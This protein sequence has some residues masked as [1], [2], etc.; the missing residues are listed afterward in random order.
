MASWQFRPKRRPEGFYFEPILRI[1]GVR[2]YNNPLAVYLIALEVLLPLQSKTTEKA[3]QLQAVWQ[4]NDSVANDY[5]F[6]A[7]R[8]NEQSFLRLYIVVLIAR[9]RVTIIQRCVARLL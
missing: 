6:V 9:F 8:R 5:R 7:R 4:N 1:D 3:R 2:S